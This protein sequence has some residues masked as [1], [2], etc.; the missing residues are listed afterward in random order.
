M[1][2]FSLCFF[3]L[4]LLNLSAVKT[5]GVGSCCRS[6]L[7]IHCL[8]DRLALFSAGCC[9]LRTLATLSNFSRCECHL[10]RWWGRLCPWSFLRGR[11]ANS[12]RNDLLISSKSEGLPI[13]SS[14]SQNEIL[15]RMR[16]RVVFRG[17]EETVDCGLFHL[18][19]VLSLI[20]LR[21]FL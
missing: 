15:L 11:L 10:F 1:P 17:L 21:E 7:C 13:R 9:L 2:F 3:R 20:I 12:Q 4:R 8:R 5:E 19:I 16:L 18:A 6:L 14:S